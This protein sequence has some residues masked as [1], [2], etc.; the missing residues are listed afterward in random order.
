MTA[1]TDDDLRLPTSILGQWCHRSCATLMSERLR[2]GRSSKSTEDQISGAR[3]DLNTK[4][5]EFLG[6]TPPLGIH[7][8]LFLERLGNEEG[9]SYRLYGSRRT[10]DIPELTGLEGIS[11]IPFKQTKLANPCHH[12]LTVDFDKGKGKLVAAVKEKYI[13]QY[14]AKQK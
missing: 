12:Q 3:S 4:A 7:V 11:S 2:L 8:A 10:I 5:I 13:A 9:S 1:T 6:Q 14:H